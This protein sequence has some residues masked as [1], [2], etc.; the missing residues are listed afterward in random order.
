MGMGAMVV[1]CYVTTRADWVLLERGASK[2]SIPSTKTLPLSLCPRQLPN[3]HSAVTFLHL[4]DCWT[5]P[6]YS[7][8]L[9]KLMFSRIAPATKRSV[10][11]AFKPTVQVNWTPTHQ[12]QPNV[13]TRH[14]IT[15]SPLFSFIGTFRLDQAPCYWSRCFVCV[16]DI[17]QQVSK[18]KIWLICFFS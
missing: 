18:K 13:Y 12:Q 17:Q 8:L 10:Q 4:S 9:L 2:F 1:V 3:F 7:S 15:H 6:P 5:I 11:Q 16:D 14:A